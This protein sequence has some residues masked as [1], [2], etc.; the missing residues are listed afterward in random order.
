MSE[1]KYTYPNFPED[2][3]FK[4]PHFSRYIKFIE[5]RKRRFL[6]EKCYV[7]K[8]H[9]IPRSLNGSDDE[10]NIVILSAREHFIAHLILWKGVGGKMIYAFWRMQ[11][12]KEDFNKCS[13]TSRQYSSLKEEI[14]IEQSK[15][16]T[17]NN[18]PMYGKKGINN[19]CYG[20]KR[21]QYG[22]KGKDNPFYGKKHSDETKK[23]LKTINKGRKWMYNDNEEKRVLP[24]E[25]NYYLKKGW[26]F[27]KINKGK[28]ICINNGI[29]SKYV[30]KTDVEDFLLNGWNIGKAYF[31][32]KKQ[33]GENHYRSQTIL[34]FKDGI[35]ERT[36]INQR[37]AIETFGRGVQSF[38]TNNIKGRRDKRVF[39]TEENYNNMSNTEFLSFLKERTYIHPMVLK[40]RNKSFS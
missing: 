17:G 3:E 6:S 36:F 1:Q 24:D 39:I 12:S 9:I 28:K 25:I 29:Q 2:L 33:V 16:V 11:Y 31:Q 37:E 34:C 19:P 30:Y 14:S 21:P 35:L 8:H 15:A 27:G 13:I 10:N 5:Q 38:L 7:E 18:N 20:I 26:V 4:E 40:K 32:V 22:L 23:H